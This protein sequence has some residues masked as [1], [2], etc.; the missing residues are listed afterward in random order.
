[1]SEATELKVIDERIILGKNFRIFGTFEEPLFLAKDVAEWRDYAKT[2]N[3][4]YDVSK[5][6]QTIDSSEKV[7]NIVRT[8]GGNESKKLMI[9]P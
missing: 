4:S 9:K 5:M 6:L 1:M 7:T 2:G 8:L 3:G